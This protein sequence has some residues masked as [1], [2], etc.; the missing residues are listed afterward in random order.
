MNSSKLIKFLLENL[1]SQIGRLSEE[2]QAKIDEGTHELTLTITKK[3]STQSVIQELSDNQK[4]E[5]LKK[6]QACNSREDGLALLAESL[7]NKKEL[8][9]FAKF[10]DV[11]VLK[12]DKAEQIRDKITEATIGAVLRSN[13][14]QGKK[15][16]NLVN[17][18]IQK[19]YLF[20][21]QLLN[22]GYTK[23]CSL[24]ILFMPEPHTSI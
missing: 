4:E 7:K 12:Q 2:D 17:S 22:A 13:A 15:H 3:K 10:L 18:D 23:F 24:G 19:L 14:I 6:L 20:T 9:Q 21:I 16:N 1:A 5:L 8:E 11:L